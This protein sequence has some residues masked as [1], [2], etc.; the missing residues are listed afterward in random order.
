MCIGDDFAATGAIF[1]INS[2]GKLSIYGNNSNILVGTSQ[3]VTANS[4]NHIAFVRS[5]GTIKAYLNGVADSTTATNSTAFTGINR[6]GGELYNGGS[7][8][9]VMLGYISNY[10]LVNGTAV[11]TTNF[12]PPTVPLTAITNTSL[13]TCQSNTFID[14]STNNFTIT[15]AGNTKATTFSPFTLSYSTRQSY[16]PSVYGGSMYFDGTGDYLSSTSSAA[17]GTGPFTIEAWVYL[18]SVGTIKMIVDNGYW[19]IGNN[20]GYRFAITSGNVL[21]LTASTGAYNTFPAVITGTTALVAGQWYHVAA[22]RDSS[23][24]INL[25]VNGVVAATPVT[26]SSSLNLGGGQTLKIGSAIADGGVY[27]TFNGYI[28]DV[29]IIPGTALYNGNFVPSNAPLTAIKNTSLLL[30]GTGAGIYDSS[31]LNN[32]ETFGD[33]KLSITTVKF[34]GST[35]VYFDGN[36]DYLRAPASRSF[37]FSTGD[38]TIELWVY[39]NSVAN[40]PH[41]WQYGAN[42]S[43][44][45][46]L[47]LASSKLTVYSG[48]IQVTGATTV[49]TGQWYH[50]AVTYVASSTTTRLF[51]NGTQDGINTTYS[52]YPKNAAD[53]AFMV[54]YQ[55]YAGAAGDYFS[56]YI[57]DLRI[58]KGVARY[59]SNFTPPTEPFDT[60]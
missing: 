32:F 6:I 18:N 50:V 38:W 5:S 44:R 40:T 41:I 23:N 11:Y 39:F 59:T 37:D 58:T 55:A 57:S 4:W 24:V 22:V 49:A 13:L 12:T 21:T 53:I 46:N 1:N 33:A 34:S 2:S 47:Y 56:G 20:G 28:S 29:R 51:L 25:Y 54:G 8:G 27:D 52:G 30:N 16:T 15:A 19:Q 35:S 3:T 14:N 60:K 43:S 17:I 48:S 31:E 45:A 36:G 42:S 10:R 7:G 26:Y 9:T